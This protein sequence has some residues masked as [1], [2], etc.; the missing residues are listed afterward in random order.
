MPV[1]GLP[2]AGFCT[3]VVAVWLADVGDGDGVLDCAG[4]EET[5]S[6]HVGVL[7]V[8]DETVGAGGGVLGAGELAV[9]GEAG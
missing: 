8:G 3:G 2:C 7:G 9:N 6:A 4:D 5:M 1:D